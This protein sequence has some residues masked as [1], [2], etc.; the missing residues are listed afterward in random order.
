MTADIKDN[1]IV[2]KTDP[3]TICIK[4][5]IATR[6]SDCQS[7]IGFRCK[8]FTLSGCDND[9]SNDDETDESDESIEEGRSVYGNLT[10]DGVKMKV[11]FD[12][13]INWNEY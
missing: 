2:Q 3:I 8:F 1:S 13:N 10:Y 4:M 7:G 12:K 5:T 6:K 11:Q 9:D